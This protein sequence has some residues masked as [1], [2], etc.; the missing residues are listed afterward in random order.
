MPDFSQS[1]VTLQPIRQFFQGLASGTDA[2]MWYFGG[3][4]FFFFGVMVLSGILLA[5]HYQPNA[6]PATAS[7]GTPLLLARITDTT[8]WLG[9]EY[10][11]GQLIPVRAD[12]TLRDADFPTPLRGSASLLRDSAT[13][14]PVHPS[15]AWVSLEHQIMRQ[16]EF[17]ALVRSV[18]AWGA[19]MLV[20]SVLIWFGGLVWRGA[21][22]RPLRA[23][24]ISGLLLVAAVF[25]AAWTGSVL[26]WDR[27]GYAAAWVGS[28][29]PEQGV[30]LVG[31]SVTELMRGG[32]DVGGAAL[33]RTAAAHTTVLPLALLVTLLLHAGWLR[34]AAIFQKP[35]HPSSKPFGSAS[36]LA[37]G[38]VLLLVIY[39]LVAAT[40]SPTSPFFLLPLLV[41][42]ASCA[43]LLNRIAGGAAS[44]A[45]VADRLYRQLVCWLL[46][47]GALVSLAVA[48]SW[49]RGE[50]GFPVD[51]SQA[52]VAAGEFRPE[53]YFLGFYQLLEWFA[54]PVVMAVISAVLL[55]FFLLPH[56]DRPASVGKGAIRW[57]VYG[58]CLLF[59]LLTLWGSIQG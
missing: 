8:T 42:P 25:G 58:L 14:N 44:P 20:A 30:P 49:T 24:W 10:V 35:E 9:V 19:Q 34:R 48:A 17:G 46:A 5:F 3:L 28:S 59:F 13:G 32:K 16:T 1:P 26:P 43:Q 51:L 22:Q 38:S 33:T 7:D 29:L 56:W 50:G 57:T 37:G 31:E 53:W 41:L 15:A 36:V 55:F 52:Q 2:L 4:V 18:H 39:P 12:S 27:L 45:N 11:P 21:W 47:A 40:F 6:A 54:V 23:V